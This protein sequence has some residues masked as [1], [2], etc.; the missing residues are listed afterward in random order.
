MSASHTAPQ[1]D[2]TPEPRPREECGIF[3]VY[4]DPE[5]ANL[6][7]LGLHGLQHRGQESAGIATV[8]P[9]GALLAHRGMGLVVDVFSTRELAALPGSCAVG[10]VRY[11]TAGQSTIR[12]CQP[13]AVDYAGGVLAIAH[14]GTLT[15]ARALR[16]G[17]ED[18][19]SLFSSSSDSEIFLH[20][21][22]RRRDGGLAERMAA[23]A[24][25]TTGA[26]SVVAMT[27]EG[28]AGLRDPFGFRP[29]VIGR[30][31]GAWFLSS[32]TAPL[33][34]IGA[35]VV[36]DVEP[37]EIVVL[38]PE[39][40]VSHRYSPRSHPVRQCVFEHVY[41]ARPDTRMFGRAVY[42]TRKELGRI[43]AEESPPPGGADIVI[44]VPDSGTTA[45]LGFAEQMRIPFEMGLIRSH[46]VGRTFIEPAQAIRN[47]GVR[48]K[49]SAVEAQIRGRR[50][51]VVDDSLVRGTTSRKIIQLLRAAGATE[52]HVRIA[53]P[54]TVSP[55]YFGIDTPT[56]GEL[57]AAHSSVDAIAD[58][59]GADTLAYLSIDGLHRAVA[60]ARFDAPG[61]RYCN[62]CFT[63][64]Y[65]TPPPAE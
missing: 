63:R 12:N 36:R 56:V 60:D 20:L 14:N 6:T 41:F 54:P 58:V 11:S 52:V 59:I 28:L 21:L 40:I 64:D 30:R 4:G 9:E 15:N 3:A 35:E 48:L 1:A 62:A 26:F 7:Y 37:G 25:E 43:L 51:V 23:V 65:P 22:A 33:A 2:V 57:I 61:R 49:L 47:F 17:L 32:E 19:G 44:P 24:A 34:L 38:G 39:G 50:V 31:D 13:F 8:S 27:Q 5:A 55:C 46:Y 16:R 18:Q 29:L 45:A 10:H 42:H 53:C